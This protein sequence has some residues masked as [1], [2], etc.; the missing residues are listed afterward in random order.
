M[1]LLLLLPALAVVIALGG[2]TV[3]LRAVERELGALRLSL[4]RSAATAVATDD[5]MR[6][7]DRLV[8]RAL[9][10]IDETR[11]RLGRRPQSWSQDRNG[12]R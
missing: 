5:L 4:R 9:A 11:L 12:R 6:A 10:E 3:G 1:P 8:E 7:S 2:L